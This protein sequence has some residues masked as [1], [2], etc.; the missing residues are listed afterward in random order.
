MSFVS[1]L[2]LAYHIV[3]PSFFCCTKRRAAKA[4]PMGPSYPFPPSSNKKL[5]MKRPNARGQ[6][7]MPRESP[8]R[9]LP[10]RLGS[11]LRSGGKQVICEL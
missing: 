10:A 2:V 8:N 4:T 7:S 1:C 5:P 11:Y 9:P 6:R 3:H